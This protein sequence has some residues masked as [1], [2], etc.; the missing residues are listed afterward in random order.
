MVLPVSRF[1]KIQLFYLRLTLWFGFRNF[2][3]LLGGF[4]TW[5]FWPLSALK[6]CMMHLFV[7]QICVLNILQVYFILHILRVDCE[8]AKQ[9]VEQQHFLDF[10]PVT[11]IEKNRKPRVREQD[12]G[13]KSMTQKDR[14][15]KKNKLI[16][17]L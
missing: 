5:V 7:L 3:G 16:S 1:L 4:I 17:F 14:Q 2:Y 6:L 12:K 8:Q 15:R 9:Q 11:S 10:A 13:I